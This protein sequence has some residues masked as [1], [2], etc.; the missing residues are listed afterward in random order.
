MNNTNIKDKPCKS[1]TL[2][3]HSTEIA[4]LKEKGA[5]FSASLS[6]KILYLQDRVLYRGIIIAVT[7]LE[8]DGPAAVTPETN[9]KIRTTDDHILL[10][11]KSCG[12]TQKEISETC[13][14]CGAKISIVTLDRK[15][16]EEKV[17]PG[18]QTPI[19]GGG[20]SKRNLFIAVG[21][22][23]LI[24]ILAAVIFLLTQPKS[25]SPPA[26]ISKSMGSHINFMVKYKDRMF[27]ESGFVA[28]DP[29][30]FKT[31]GFQIIQGRLP[32]A[33]DADRFSTVITMKM[34]KKYF[35][36]RGPIGEIL[37]LNDRVEFRIIGVVHI[38]DNSDI[39]ADFFISSN[40]YKA[41][42]GIT[43]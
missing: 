17:Q 20:K 22:V 35:A 26:A 31:F 2:T 43:E 14:D 7:Q 29:E 42:V 16:G 9:V 5:D 18:P 28:A 8:P 23:L 30:F 25:S 4:T 40:G 39:Q 1:V 15:T 41:I 10:V 36:D 3:V 12:H 11:C 33:H 34:A 32:M 13:S 37:I 21:A 38:P 27:N 6:G 19:P 24:I